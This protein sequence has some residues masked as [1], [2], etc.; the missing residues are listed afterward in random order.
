MLWVSANPGCGKSVLAKYLVDSKLQTTE[1]RT[2][3]YFFFKDDFEDQ[4]SATS[5]L[6]CILHQL[7]IQREDLFSNKIVKRLEAYK[8]HL[9]KEPISATPLVVRLDGEK[10]YLPIGKIHGVREGSE[11]TTYPPTTHVTF[12]VDRVDD[13]ECRALV[14]SV[15]HAQTLQRHHYQILP[16]RWSL[17]DETLQ[18]LADASLG[19]EFQQALH[20]AL[21]DRIVGDI[22]VTEPS[23]SYGPDA[24]VFRVTKRDDGGVDLA[25]S[26]PLI[27]YEG[28]V[29]GLDLTGANTAQLATKSAIALAHLT[30]FRQIFGLSDKAPKQLA[31]FELTLKPKKNQGDLSCGQG[32]DFEF[33]NTAG[34]QLHLTVLVLSSGFHVK[35]LY[36]SQDFPASVDPG[37]EI[38]FTFNMTIPDP[39]NGYREQ[40]DIIRVVVTRGR[41]LSWRSLELPNIWNADQLDSKRSSLGRDANLLSDFSWWVKDNVILTTKQREGDKVYWTSYL[42]G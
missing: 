41:Q 6:S 40:R 8:E 20:A 4:R 15:L 18:V 10:I 24:A 11:F 32:I 17:G 33:R 2:T 23:D 1:P 31:P 39:L 25:G 7:F 19:S 3:C 16:C 26:P 42:V 29:R 22:E 13:F 34:S 9:T 35:Q 38:P 14:P 27:G 12:S 21:Q 37:R 28:S 30:R 36:P 5:A